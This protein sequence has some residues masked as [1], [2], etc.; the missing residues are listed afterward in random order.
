M[1]TGEMWQKYSLGGIAIHDGGYDSA[2]EN[3]DPSAGILVGAAA[4]WLYREADNGIEVLF[5]HRSEFVDSNAGKWDIS[6]A[7]HMNYGETIIEAA[8]RE[9]KEEIG[10]D[11]FED[12]LKFVISCCG[13]EKNILT[14]H[15]IY[16]F[17]GYS[18]D[19]HFD[20][21]EVSEVKWI[22]F[23]DFDNFID[24]NVK[25]SVKNNSLIR[26]A[27]KTRL[28]KICEN[29]TVYKNTTAH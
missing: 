2:L 13:I 14:H 23:D 1:H 16:N 7:G 25:T 29:R 3:P 18:D 15:F 12:G 24:K 19:F 21:K 6:A 26:T 27:I 28:E 4:V 5:Q 22:P 9:A 10:I 17:T 20:D 8:I 11:I